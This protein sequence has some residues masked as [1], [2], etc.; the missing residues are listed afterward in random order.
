MNGSRGS[1]RFRSYGRTDITTFLL[2][3]LIFID[4]SHQN[5]FWNQLTPIMLCLVTRLP[6][7]RREN[8]MIHFVFAFEGLTMY[9][10]CEGW[11]LAQPARL[12]WRSPLGYVFV[13]LW[14]GT[15]WIIPNF[16][17][18]KISRICS[19]GNWQAHGKSL[20]TLDILFHNNECNAVYSYQ[21]SRL[22]NDATYG[23]SHE[24]MTLSNL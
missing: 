2:N 16:H 12:V 17:E 24:Y 18:S 7:K 22:N 1:C 9:S 13:S 21:S 4:S 15:W 10:S 8:L 14:H 11:T 3:Q 20:A 23:K 19:S 5:S 6:T